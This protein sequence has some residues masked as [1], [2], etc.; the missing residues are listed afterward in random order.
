MSYTAPFAVLFFR[1]VPTM[2]EGFWIRNFRSFKHL[3][4]GSGFDIFSVVDGDVDIDPF[5]LGPVT[6]FTGDCGVGKSTILDA[7]LFLSDC[8]YQGLDYTCQKRGGFENILFQGGGNFFS[9]GIDFRNEGDAEPTTYA[10]RV[11]SDKNK[12]P[13][14]ESELLVFRNTERSFPIIY[15]QNGVQSIRYLAPDESFTSADLTKIE[16]T[17]YNHLGLAS[18][19][20][21]PKYPVYAAVRKTIENFVLS[22]ITSDPARGLDGAASRRQFSPRGQSLLGI[23]RSLVAQYGD[24]TPRLLDR[25][26]KFLPNVEEIVLDATD[27]DIPKLAFKVDDLARPIP[28]AMLSD[29]SVRLLAFALL[30]EEDNPAPLVAIE[31]PENGFD[32]PHLEQYLNLARRLIDFPRPLQLFVTTHS[33]EIFETISASNIWLL[34]KRAGEH[35]VERIGDKIG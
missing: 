15:L 33:P 24:G 14:I 29:A 2:I 5:E 30:L 1:F 9:M 19:S 4:I 23:V 10:V 26:V 11:G 34:E 12:V 28:I 21:H 27:P 25:I 7:F 31:E 18:L 35:I 22:G 6:V 32:G 17:N 16:F 13:F 8:F 20:D 3:G